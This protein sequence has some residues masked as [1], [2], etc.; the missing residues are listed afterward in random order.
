MG[1]RE[2]MM[3]G[4]LYDGNNG[5]LLGELYRAQELCQ[6]Y[7]ALRITDFEGR[8]QLLDKLIPQHGKH[9][10]IVPPFYCDYGTNI[11]CGD[12]V[13]INCCCVFLDEAPIKIGNNVFIAPQCGFYT[14][15]HPLDKEVRRKNIQYALPITIGDDVW[16]GGMV[17]IMPGVTIG[18]GTVVAGGSVVTRDIPEG[19]LAAGNPCRVI[20]TITDDEKDRFKSI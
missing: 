7:N 2:E 8:K 13:F 11:E 18:S 4:R 14:A 16:I 9:F 3:S 19:V 5:E 15:G 10:S 20:R 1:M 17:T 12:H 6:D